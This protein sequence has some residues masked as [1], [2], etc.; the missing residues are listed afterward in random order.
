MA[1]DQ[2]IPEQVLGENVAVRAL[3]VDILP[4]QDDPLR[5]IVPELDPMPK[6]QPDERILALAKRVVG[7]RDT[8][9]SPPIFDGLRFPPR[10][11]GR[12]FCSTEH[13]RPTTHRP[14]DIPPG[15]HRLVGRADKS[16]GVR[17]HRDLLAHL[18]ASRADPTSSADERGQGVADRV[19]HVV[20]AVVQ[21]RKH[22]A[23]PRVSLVAPQP[24][25]F[26]RPLAAGVNDNP[27][28]PPEMP[29]PILW[30]AWPLLHRFHPEAPPVHL[31]DPLR[32]RRVSPDH[33]L[34]RAGN[35]LKEH[36]RLIEVELGLT[37]RILHPEAAIPD[38]HPHQHSRVHRKTPV[39]TVVWSIPAWLR[40]EVVNE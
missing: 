20:V 38:P 16:S 29:N 31:V 32:A 12:R 34:L 14:A 23:G 36:G 26:D 4:V 13:F 28:V 10:E 40:S 33:I 30:R 21:F 27:L 25:L 37:W 7:K 5:D 24:K 3:A 17:R 11:I 39:G 35:F 6:R 22:V 1:V 15:L 2:R 9:P 18:Y 8:L 19:G